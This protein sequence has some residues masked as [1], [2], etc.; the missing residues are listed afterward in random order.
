MA[1]NDLWCADYK[2]QFRLGDRS[3]CY[4]LT[5]SDH[6]SRYLFTCDAHDSTKTDAAFSTFEAAFEEFG[7]PLAI[8]SDNGV[9][10]ASRALFG[11]SRLSVWWMRLGI[12]VERI[13]P[14]H[15]EQNG[16]HERIHR[17][18]KYDDVVQKPSLSILKQQDRLELFRNDYNERRPHE[19][20]GNQTPSEVYSK[21]P[22]LYSAILKDPDYD[23][24]DQVHRSTKCGSVFFCNSTERIFL[25]PAFGH[26]PVALKEEEDDHWR[27]QFMDLNLGYYDRHEGIFH[28]GDQ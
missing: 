15:P 18:L 17:T 6:F 19:S 23:G 8:R 11:H 12:R 3:Y 28:R 4:P 25:G 27:V 26:Q 13:K 22:R 16:R 21:S 9:P 20:L 7:L 5:I 10:F 1:P 24:F 14:G 2:G